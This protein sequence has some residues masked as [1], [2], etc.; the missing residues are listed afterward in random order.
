MKAVIIEDEQI[1]ATALEKLIREVV[2]D[3]E[4]LAVLQSIDESV[5]WLQAHPMPDLLFMDIHL[6]D[7]SSFAIFEELKVS[8]P[9]IFTTA[10]DE[11]ALKAFEV[12]SLD[13]LLKPINKSDLERAIGKFNKLLNVLP[14]D[15]SEWLEQLARTFRQQ[16]KKYR[17][18]FLTTVKDRLVPVATENIAC[19]FIENKVVRAITLDEKKHVIDLSMEE[20]MIQLNPTDFFRANRQYIIARGAVKDMVMWFGNKLAVNLTVPT[21]ERIYISRTHVRE[22][23]N[24]ITGD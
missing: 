8:C 7:G 6:A 13:Y 15:S 16:N 10:Y 4:I 9:V 20:V 2:P 23:K 18:S 14:A 12:Y 1:A 22:F 3:M 21:P 19:F 17:T 5:E 11:Y 24:W